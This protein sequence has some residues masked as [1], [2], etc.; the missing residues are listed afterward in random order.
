MRKPI[1]AG[2]MALM[3]MASFSPAHANGCDGEM[4]EKCFD[5]GKCG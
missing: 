3:A 4:G 1:Y 2:A 5:S